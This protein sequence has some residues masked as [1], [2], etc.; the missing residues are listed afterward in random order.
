MN[1]EITKNIS[2]IKAQIYFLLLKLS[3]ISDCFSYLFIYF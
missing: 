2:Q 1:K 3:G